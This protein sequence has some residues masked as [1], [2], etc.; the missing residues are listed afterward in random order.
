M[1]AKRRN[2]YLFV[3]IALILCIV[4]LQQF[5]RKEG[6]TNSA[7][8]MYDYLAPSADRKAYP[9]SDD[10]IDKFTSKMNSIPGA[11]PQLTSEQVK[12]IFPNWASETEAKYY[13]QNGQWPM[14]AYIMN[15]IDPHTNL[16]KIAIEAGA[17]QKTVL[18]NT[19]TN[20]TLPNYFPVRFIFH[21]LLVG[22]EAKLGT[23]AFQIYMGTA[24]APTSPENSLLGGDKKEEEKKNKQP[25]TEIEKKGLPK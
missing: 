25:T 18:G 12:V 20:E 19:L 8:G 3:V 2:F 17:A 1:L 24:P 7:S 23:L 21:T 6:M 15:F 4:L 14:N 11:T 10:V 5:S 9:W 13:I 16:V 22:N